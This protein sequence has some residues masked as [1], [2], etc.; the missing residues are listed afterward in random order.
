MILV[1]SNSDYSPESLTGW[2]FKDDSFGNIINKR[3]IATRKQ[4]YR[5]WGLKTI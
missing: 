4:V 5:E 1:D 2:L 3:G